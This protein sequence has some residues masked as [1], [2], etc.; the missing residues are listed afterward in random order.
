MARKRKTDAIPRNSRQR[1]LQ[2]RALATVS[3]M[4]RQNLPLKLAIKVERIRGA[5]VRRYAGSALE[6]SN[7]DYRVK[8]LDR[9]PRRLQVLGPKG[10]EPLPTRSSRQASQIGRYM[11]AL[12]TFVRTGKQ[13]ELKKFKGKRVPGKKY[14]FIVNPKKLMQLADV[15]ILDIERLY[16]GAKKA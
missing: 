7:G 9:I 1:E 8:R 11:N 12:K 6:E 5:T 16:V 13:T 3:L 10:M 15:G 4:R 14:N 2:E